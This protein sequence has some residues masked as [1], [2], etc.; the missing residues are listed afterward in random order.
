MTFSKFLSEDSGV[1]IS[2]SVIKAERKIIQRLDDL[3][4]LAGKFEKLGVSSKNLSK[5]I[6]NIKI[7][8]TSVTRELVIL[9]K[10]I[11]K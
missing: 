3:K 1:S 9:S 7:D 8:L 10:Q 4:N 5:K 11:V 2:K 6:D